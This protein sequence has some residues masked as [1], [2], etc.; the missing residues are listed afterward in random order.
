MAT[1][2]MAVA[3]R[4]IRENGGQYTHAAVWL[5]MACL[6]LGMAGEGYQILHALL[7]AGKDSKVYRAEPYVLAADVYTGPDHLGRGGWS[8]YTGA[9]GWFYRAAVED[10]GLPMKPFRYE[11]DL[12]ATEGAAARLRAYLRKNLRPGEAVELWNLWVGEGAVRPRRFSGALGDVAAD[13]LEQLAEGSQTCL[14][15]E[16]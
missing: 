3:T 10:L 11:L 12:E 14:T 8:W 4:G 5:A 6:R 15:V 9:A 13:T 2:M 16:I 7:P 1:R